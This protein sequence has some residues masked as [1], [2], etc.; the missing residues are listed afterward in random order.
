V[1]SN[2]VHECS[3]C[4]AEFSSGQALGGHMRRHKAFATA[5]STTTTTT[6]TTTTSIMSLGRVNGLDHES[7]ESKKPRNNLQLDLNLLAPKDDLLE[8]KFHFAL[9][10]KFLSSQLLP[11]L[12]S[13]T[14]PI[15]MEIVVFSFGIISLQIQ[16]GL[17]NFIFTNAIHIC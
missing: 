15:K 12:I 5:T 6:T 9:R 17:I 11:W 13:I 1:K 16:F 3:I 10:N 8:P 14:N 2:K 7:Q 4:G